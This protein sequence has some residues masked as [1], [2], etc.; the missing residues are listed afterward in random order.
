MRDTGLLIACDVRNR[1]MELLRRTVEASGAKHVRLVQ[2]D[3]LRPLPFTRPFDCVLVDAPCS[4]LGILRRDPDI[5]W[6]RRESDLQLLAAAQLQMLS[7]AADAVAPGG[8]LIYAP[9]LGRSSGR[10]RRFTRPSS[11]AAACAR[12]RGVFRRGIRKARA[13]LNLRA[14]LKARP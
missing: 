14:G 8:R 3:L 4:G 11:D 5:R 9:G 6:R 10:R 1:R 2:A 13:G 12:A 7:Q